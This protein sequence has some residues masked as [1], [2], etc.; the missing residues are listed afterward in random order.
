MQMLI[1]V[2]DTLPQ[3]LVQQRIKELE[4]RLKQ[5]AQQSQKAASRWEKM[6]QRI[7]SKA[8]DLEDHTDTFNRDRQE[9]RESLNFK[10]KPE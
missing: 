5:E 3:A 10:D 7:E 8:F 9:F 2:P 6:V 4:E 1:N